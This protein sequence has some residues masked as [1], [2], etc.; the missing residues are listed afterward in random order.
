MYGNF[1]GRYNERGIYKNEKSLIK[2]LQI[3]KTWSPRLIALQVPYQAPIPKNIAQQ[4]P[5][6]R[7]IS[8][9]IFNFQQHVNVNP[10][11]QVLRWTKIILGLTFSK[12]D[13]SFANMLSTAIFHLLLSPTHFT[14]SLASLGDDSGVLGSSS[15]IKC[16]SWTPL[17]SLKLDLSN[18]TIW[19]SATW[20]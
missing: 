7:L 2:I 4:S 1:Y 5:T 20:E 10:S 16:W 6:K 18:S 9:A 13:A 17:L 11:S 15:T 3:K 14:F 8:H 12:V 19:I